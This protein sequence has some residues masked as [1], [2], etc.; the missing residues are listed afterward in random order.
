MIAIAI[1]VLAGVYLLVPSILFDKIV[2]FFVPAKK[3]ARSRADEILYGLIVAFLPIGIVFAFSHLWYSIG[4]YPFALPAGDYARK[5]HDYHTIVLALMSDSFF[6]GHSAEVWNSVY[7]AQHLQAR[8]L[9]WM[10]IVFGIQTATWVSLLKYYGRLQQF[11]LYRSVSPFIVGRVSEWHLLLTTFLFHPSE[12]RVVYA[13]VVTPD[14]LYQGKVKNHFTHNDGSLAGILLEGASRFRLKELNEV[15]KTWRDGGSK[16]PK[17]RTKDFW[18]KIAGGTHLYIPAGQISNLNVR[19]ER[20]GEVQEADALKS[21]EKENAVQP[22]IEKLNAAALK[23]TVTMSSPQ[24]SKRQPSLSKYEFNQKAIR[25]ETEDAI[26]YDLRP[27]GSQQQ[28]AVALYV[29]ELV[30]R[31]S[32]RALGTTKPVILQVDNTF[33]STTQ[34]DS[35]IAQLKAIGLQISIDKQANSNIDDDEPEEGG[36]PAGGPDLN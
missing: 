3:F 1:S 8:F 5:W 9:F 17:P 29:G 30:F 21:L 24:L 36:K 31:N 34:I 22:L 12:G 27:F 26:H 19:Y 7:R 14:G 33:E 16:G 18:T 28:I 32:V 13:D 25:T 20:P 15:R 6:K 11:R 2:S 23:L 35:F 4:N 10:Y